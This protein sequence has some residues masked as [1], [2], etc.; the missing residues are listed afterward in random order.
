M[1]T[2][3]DFAIDRTSAEYVKNHPNYTAR[4]G[5]E[6]VDEEVKK[7]ETQEIIR[8]PK[9]KKTKVLPIA[10]QSKGIKKVTIIS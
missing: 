6:I 4:E 5:E 8:I 3:K 2:Q 10:K 1:F 9:E 7:V